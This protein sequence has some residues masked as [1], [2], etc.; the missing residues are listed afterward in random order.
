MS[1]LLH[2]PVYGE[3]VGITK[4]VFEEDVEVVNT[5]AGRGKHHHFLS[6]PLAQEFDQGGQFQFRL[7]NK[8]EVLEAGRCSLVRLRHP[9]ALEFCASNV[10]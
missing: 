1:L 5:G 3:D 8:V 2:L 10:A 9:V 4:Q 7:T 6:R